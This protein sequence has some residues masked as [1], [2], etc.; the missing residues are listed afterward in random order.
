V[1]LFDG[2][3]ATE[4]A[5]Y[6]GLAGVLPFLADEALIFV[7]DANDMNIN[8]AVHRFELAY[9]T[10]ILKFLTIPTPGNC[11]PMFWNGVI[12]LAWKRKP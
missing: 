12:A 8:R 4:E 7:D 1:Y 9:P 5:A 6:E 3:K 10:Q 11:W 2:D